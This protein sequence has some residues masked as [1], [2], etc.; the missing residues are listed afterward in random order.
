VLVLSC[1]VLMALHRAR[2][3]ANLEATDVLEALEVVSIC[4]AVACV[5]SGSFMFSSSSF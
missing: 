5:R 3:V 1:Q 4:I 2:M